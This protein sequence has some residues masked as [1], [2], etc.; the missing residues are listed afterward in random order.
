MGALRTTRST[1]EFRLVRSN[2][3]SHLT[4]TSAQNGSFMNPLKLF[5]ALFKSAPRVKAPACF[6]RV[7]RGDAVLVDVRERGEW[8][9]GVAEGAVLLSL[10]DLVGARREWRPFLAAHADREL[11]LYCAAGGRSAIAARILA[12]EG[13]R[14]ADA[15][16]LREWARAGWPIVPPPKSRSQ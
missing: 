7:R 13:F 6:E 10:S 11:L 5:L 8:P 3:L 9:Q 2:T 14:T 15:G 16:S 4:K 12:K 1:D